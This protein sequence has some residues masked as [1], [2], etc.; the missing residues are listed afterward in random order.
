MAGPTKEPSLASEAR[1]TT[2]ARWVAH[3]AAKLVAGFRGRDTALLLVSDFDGTLAEL[4]PD[5]WGAVILPHAQRALRRLAAA[6]G[7]SVALLSGRGVADLSGRARIGGISYLG[8]HGA[9]WAEAPRGFRVD[10]LRV[11]REPASSAELAMAA[12]LC[13]AVPRAVPEPWLVV[14]AKGPAVTFH[15]RIAPDVDA[16][17]ARVTAAV[18]AVDAEGLLLR[19][20][21]RRSLE[22]RPVSATDKG[23]ALRRLID[24]RRPHAVIMLGDDPSDVLAFDALREARSAGRIRGLAVAVAGHPDVSAVVAPQADLLLASPRE[25]AR[26]LRLLGADVGGGT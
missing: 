18:D 23:V 16:A 13:E 5:P 3:Q 12:C 25:A 15:F 21:G 26:F 20:G 4:V 9:E 17:R 1:A 19:S 24:G 6:P 7:V 11:Q 22:L 2:D 10:A 14:E 8:D